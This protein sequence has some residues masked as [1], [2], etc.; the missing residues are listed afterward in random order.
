M[1]YAPFVH[2][3]VHSGYSLLTSSARVEALIQRA[4]SL[5]MPALALTDHGNLFAAIPFFTGCLKAGIK[6]ILGAQ[7][8]LVPNRLDRSQRPDQ[9]IRDQLLLLC[10]NK[11]GWQNLLRL[12]SIGH[13]EG[14]HEKP[15]IDWELLQQHHRGLLA[16]SAGL[17]GEV[18]RLLHSGRREQA[19]QVALHLRDLFAETLPSG[20]KQPGF[21]LELQRHGLPGEEAVNQEM[22]ALAQQWEIPLLASNDIHFIHPE[23][24]RAQD[25]LL[26]IGLGHTLFAENR[27]RYTEQH[28][29]PTPEQMA[30]RFAD[31]PEALANTLYVA[32]RCNLQLELGKTVLPDYQPPA[33][34][35]L[36]SCLRREAEEGLQR[37]LREVVLLDR[38]QQEHSEVERQYQERLAYE[39]EVILQM[40]FSGY[41]LIVSDFIR[42]AKRNNI[43]VGPGRGS[44]AGSLVAWAL[45]ITDL[46]PI[47]YQLL[48]ERFLNPERVSMPD[49]DVDFCMDNRE[50][51]IHYVRDKYGADRVAQIITFGTLQA[52]A[53]IRDVGRVLEFPYGRVDRIA[54]LIPATLGITLAEAIEQEP[55]LRQ[56]MEDE[57]EV[58]DLLEL[59]MALEGLP[60][61][62][63]THAAGVVMANGPLT[64]MVPL[65]R[66]PRSEMPVTQFNM[67]DV[68]K[69]GLVK[70]DFLGLKTLTVIADVLR[71]V[72][73]R[74]AEMGQEPL[75]I[76]RIDLQDKKTY[77]LLKEGQTRGI[78]QL[79][80]SG[81]REI[82]KK[83]APDS[84]EEIVALVALYRPGP[85]GSGMVDDFINRKHRRVE[86]SYPLPM[87]EPILQE[88]FGVILYQ[89][90]VMKIA[91][92]MAGY[93]LGGADLLRRAMGKK[94]L[95][96]MLSQR[97]IFV[98]GSTANGISTER[99][100]YVF[101]LMEK[102][103]GYGFNK[104]HSAAYALIS[105]QT[106]WLK[107]HYAVEFMAAT[108]TCDMLNSDKVALFIHECR[109]LR[110]PV[111]PPDINVSEAVFTTEK[112]SDGNGLAI[113]YGL[114]AIKNVGEGAVASLLKVRQQS[115]AFR[116][117][118]ELCRRVSG[119]NR[120]MMEQ[121]IKAGACDALGVNRATLLD[122]LPIAMSR[123]SR[124]QEAVS[125]GFRDLFAGQEVDEELPALPEFT[126]SI[127][128][129]YE[130]D[131]LG[132][133][134]TGHPMD[135]YRRELQEYG[136]KTIAEVKI[137]SAY[138]QADEEPTTY[139]NA[140]RGG[141]EGY[142]RVVGMVSNRKLHRTRKGE[143]MAFLTL[144]DA[145]GQLEITVFADL[146]QS[147][148][149]LL[150]ELP[151]AG[152]GGGAGGRVLIF[153]GKME[154]GEDEV[155][156]LAEEILDLDEW[157]QQHCRLLH[158]RTPLMLVNDKL[159][160]Q[161]QG[162]LT[163]HSGG[164]CRV[165][166]ELESQEAVT[167]LQLGQEYA[168]LPSQGLLEAVRQLF[169][170]DGAHFRGFLL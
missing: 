164:H 108:L 101:D 86:V 133:Y 115:G 51:V 65:Y 104:S 5:R 4:K 9:E 103:A 72:N 113:R 76:N 71:L 83:L 139:F 131:A 64:D 99:S 43:P 34:E 62:A 138:S 121:L 30:E 73:R 19:E 12:V 25:A 15:R 130:K 109:E 165:L 42:W 69:A 45:E 96:E 24:Y 28:A 135:Q 11:E 44:G 54:K 18:G 49:F 31:L 60:R 23:E 166:W 106:A 56:L 93:T 55:Q 3:H 149:T 152:E 169:G 156:M 26:C 145:D 92:V 116:T 38:P 148:H 40:G 57:E 91:Q 94:K 90:Q 20:E 39:L 13:L 154:R 7:L 61:S 88:T 168:V 162:I 59:A 161:L 160:E 10:R 100:G 125:F 29:F 37:C 53:V 35:D 27:P 85:L 140:H 136:L 132:F 79:E 127:K 102:F 119:L 112:R 147:R 98:S 120:R 2:L 111:L 118:F 153:S 82:L 155:K 134:V 137:F 17:K 68:E 144:E 123:G 107:A 58:K 157:R 48:F 163:A 97:E 159:L 63:G 122:H 89:E 41:F 105:Y 77:Q 16:L 75:H 141:D 52:R 124:K 21:F 142:V 80:S 95:Q 74:R 81:M 46:D 146:Y 117:L 70:F 22:V 33:G 114:A 32:E 84:F 158:V 151:I 129:L 6:P 14:S 110:I 87:L 170:P 67:G 1:S 8:Y 78:F 150:E 50:R 47:R 128:L 143:R 36:D 167:G 126:D 66:D